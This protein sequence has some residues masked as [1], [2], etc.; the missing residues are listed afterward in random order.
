MNNDLYSQFEKN[1]FSIRSL[2]SFDKELRAV[3]MTPYDLLNKLTE[4]QK[5]ANI[6]GIINEFSTNILDNITKLSEALSDDEFYLKSDKE[7][8]EKL[9]NDITTVRHKFAAI[10]QYMTAE[11]EM[12]EYKQEMINA[13]K[14]AVLLDRDTSLTDEERTAKALEIKQEIDRTIGSYQSYL[15]IYFSKQREYLNVVGS[16]NV[17]DFKNDVL[18]S[19]NT[20]E[21]DTKGLAI[22][23][24]TRARVTDIVSKM[25]E[26]TV[27]F[28]N[29]NIRSQIDFEN[30]CERYG[31]VYNG[32]SLNVSQTKSKTEVNNQTE[33][34]D[35]D[36]DLTNEEEKKEEVKE[37]SEEEQKALDD[38]LKSKDVNPDYTGPVKEGEQ[39]AVVPNLDKEKEKP[40]DPTKDSSYLGTVDPDKQIAVVDSKELDNPEPE[41]TTPNPN[42]P[43]ETK[44][45][46]IKV[47][48][49]R[50]CKWI[51]EHKKQILIA[52]GIALLIVAVIVA[53]QY[54]I[55]AITTMLETSQVAT[56]SSAMMENGALWHG[57]IASEQAALHGA[58]TALA[59]AIQSMTGS[60]ALF[61]TT[62]GIWTIGGT[63]LGK[64]TTAAIA[65]AA[66]AS[67]AATAISNGVMG[68]GI[69]GLG[70]TGLGAILP[71]KSAAYKNILK[72]IKDLKKNLTNMSHEEVQKKVAEIIAQINADANLTDSEKQRL[73]GKSNKLISKSEKLVDN[74]TLEASAYLDLNDEIKALNANIAN[75]SEEEISEAIRGLIT[76]IR[77]TNSLT[78]EEM[79]VLVKKTRKVYANYRKLMDERNMEQ[80]V[81][82]A[83]E[84]EEGRGR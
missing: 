54:L 55:P 22:T 67:S 16:I 12:L 57:A 14:K 13:K 41:K 40:K 78:K 17:V 50:A 3:N 26:N 29:S 32:K 68:L 80:Q 42:H 27:M 28:A 37:L 84:Q 79:E 47:V 69:T 34:K 73:T 30:M 6:S 60:Q 33:K 64:F 20:I 31:L 8:L 35:N 52:V 23:N 21:D 39:L 45:P 81:K 76:K 15:S 2:V 9:Q 58:N 53:L 11:K 49:R 66:S 82:D 70:L 72:S 24:D 25:R 51:N 1:G 7:K 19:I 75:M 4:L 38:T 71:K 46:K 65:N 36:K 5:G 43:N 18:K 62:T 83:Q 61:N 10:S 44:E 77:N 63:E 56:L 48:A 59:S 74:D